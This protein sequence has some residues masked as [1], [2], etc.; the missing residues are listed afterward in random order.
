MGDE[1]FDHMMKAEL[2]AMALRA[3]GVSVAKPAPLA[4]PAAADTVFVFVQTLLSLKD[5][6]ASIEWSKEES[7]LLVCV[8]SSFH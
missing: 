3:S 7:R 8:C 5:M 2:E 6:Q 1:E 4:K